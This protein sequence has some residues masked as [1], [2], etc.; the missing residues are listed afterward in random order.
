MS[1]LVLQ[2]WQKNQIFEAIQKAGLDPRE[3]DLQDGDDKIFVN[4]RSSTSFFTIRYDGKYI[5]NYVIGDAPEWSYEQYSW[6]PLLDRIKRWLEEVKRDLEMPDLWN[7]LRREA[8]LLGFA[9]EETA[10]NTPFTNAEQKEI[11]HKL[12]KLAE[13]AKIMHSFSADQMQDLHTKINYL[14]DAAGRLGRT[15]WRG[16]F[17]GV[18]VSY[19]LT[20]GIPPESARSVFL[21]FIA[22]LRSIGSIFGHGLPELPIW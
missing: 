10:E 4:H 18:I 13:N 20:A 5:G 1:S 12:Q 3:F 6:Q 7:D 2:K 21:T 9:S 22:F 11:G 15:D 8:E 14:I 17:V 16:V 19:I